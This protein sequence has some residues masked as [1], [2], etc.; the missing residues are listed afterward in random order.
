[1]H[2]I[3]EKYPQN[4]DVKIDLQTKNESDVTSEDQRIEQS[5]S[6]ENK[7]NDEKEIEESEDI[8]E[9]EAVEEEAIDLNKEEVINIYIS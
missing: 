4:K 6:E 2:Y 8:K 9:I 5:Q 7:E 1:L 3:S